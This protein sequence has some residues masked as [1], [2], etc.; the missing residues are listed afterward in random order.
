MRRKKTENRKYELQWIYTIN[1]LVQ[2][3]GYATKRQCREA[4]HYLIREAVKAGYSVEPLQKSKDRLYVKYI[5]DGKV[6]EAY[7]L[8]R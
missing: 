8:C 5:E 6:L 3:K 4:M 7:C 2:Q 1:G